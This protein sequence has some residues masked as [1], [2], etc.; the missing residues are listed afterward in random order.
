MGSV[1]HHQCHRVRSAAS[2]DVKNAMEGKSTEEIVAA[3]KERSAEHS[4]PNESLVQCVS[5]G[6][7]CGQEL[8]TDQ[9]TKIKS[10][11]DGAPVRPFSAPNMLSRHKAVQCPWPVMAHDGPC[12]KG[13]GLRFLVRAC[14]RRL[15]WHPPEFAI[16]SL[17]Q[18]S[19]YRGWPFLP[20]LGEEE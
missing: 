18:R 14:A 10:A 5:I 13:V 15:L 4:Q 9:L 2:T 1:G 12:K 19:G 17:S 11:L 7:T 16:E 3:L 8:P 6:C 20:G